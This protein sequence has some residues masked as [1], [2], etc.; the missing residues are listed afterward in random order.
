M[1]ETYRTNGLEQILGKLRQGQTEA[2]IYTP[3]VGEDGKGVD[4]P[5]FAFIDTLRIS[6]RLPSLEEK[7]LPADFEELDD[8]QRRAIIRTFF[9]DG[10][11]MI[12]ELSIVKGGQEFKPAIIGIVNRPPFY[13]FSLMTYLTDAAVFPL[14]AGCEL[15]ARVLDVGWGGLS[16]DDE[17]IIFGSARTEAPAFSLP[18]QQVVLAGAGGAGGGDSTGDNPTFLGQPVTYEG[19]RLTYEGD[20]VTYIS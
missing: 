7:E 3:E 12:F 13:H 8:A 6:I 18:P 5:F 19:D 4:L 1:A 9:Y 20:V 14:A 2:T 16:G 10:P 11:N 17:I 15:K